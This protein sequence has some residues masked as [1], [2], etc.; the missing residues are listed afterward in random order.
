MLN[1]EKRTLEELW[2][3]AEV[4]CNIA[5]LHFTTKLNKLINGEVGN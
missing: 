1:D 4:F 2:W 3:L 5:F